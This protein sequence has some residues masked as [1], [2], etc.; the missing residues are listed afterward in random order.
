M[1]CCDTTRAAVQKDVVGWLHVSQ[2]KNSLVFKPECLEKPNTSIEQQFCGQK[3]LADERSE[4]N[5]QTGLS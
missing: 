4:E 5:I 3:W 2:R 1:S